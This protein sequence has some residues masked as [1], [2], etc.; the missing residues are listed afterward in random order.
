M[1]VIFDDIHTGGYLK[2]SFETVVI[3][4]PDNIVTNSI[5]VNGDIDLAC[6]LFDY[7]FGFH[8]ESSG[9]SCCGEDYIIKTSNNFE[10]SHIMLIANHNMDDIDKIMQTY[11]ENETPIKYRNYIT[12]YSEDYDCGAYQAKAIA[13]LYNFDTVPNLLDTDIIVS[14]IIS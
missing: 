4:I 10:K 14:D 7:R 9:C 2:T 12:I 1:F 13:E 3:G 5:P 6:Y 11:F 8:P